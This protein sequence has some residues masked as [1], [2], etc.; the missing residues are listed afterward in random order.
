MMSFI[1]AVGS[2][3][4]VIAAFFYELDDTTMGKIELELESRKLQPQI[5]EPEVLI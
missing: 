2:L 3:I 4:A 1:P 5:N